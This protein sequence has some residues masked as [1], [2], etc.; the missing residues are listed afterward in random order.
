MAMTKANLQVLVDSGRIEKLGEGENAK[1]L[2]WFLDLKDLPA[3]DFNRDIIEKGH[4]EAP[5]GCLVMRCDSD[6]HAVANL[7]LEF[8]SVSC[9][10]I[11]S[12]L[13]P[14]IEK[15]TIYPDHGDHWWTAIYDPSMEVPREPYELWAEIAVDGEHFESVRLNTCVSE[16]AAAAK[17]KKLKMGMGGTGNAAI[18][19]RRW[20]GGVRK[21]VRI[22]REITG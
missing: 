1:S 4:P 5:D 20:E 10:E 13:W 22:L 14:E 7:P 8:K 18:W 17:A 15:P 3:W 21:D 2:H 9:E 12:V 11:V 6:F 19:L 16:E